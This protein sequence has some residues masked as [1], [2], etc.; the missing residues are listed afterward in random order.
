MAASKA[1]V[2][3]AVADLATEQY[4]DDAVAAGGGLT[5]LP[6]AST[7]TKG[8][9]K[10]GTTS[11]TYVNCT[12]MNG[13]TIGVVQSSNVSKGVNYKG[14]C[15]I[16]SN[17]TPTASEYQQGCLVFSTSTNSLYIRT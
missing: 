6:T 13:E 2:D 12:K 11:G 4:V 7:S 9:V 8:G 15:C 14:Q 17:S 1:Y 10:A 16:T 3:E 5:E